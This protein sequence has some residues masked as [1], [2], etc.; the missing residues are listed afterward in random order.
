MVS[1]F[2]DV[3]DKQTF[4]VCWTEGIRGNVIQELKERS[5]A[6]TTVTVTGFLYLQ[7]VRR[8]MVNHLVDLEDIKKSLSVIALSHPALS[9]SL[10]D[11]SGNE[12]E[13]Y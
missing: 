1:R 13:S 8:K 4:K 3:P 12:N 5:T 9:V 7:P 6:G 10:R 2:K 11:V